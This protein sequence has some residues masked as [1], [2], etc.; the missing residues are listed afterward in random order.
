MPMLTERAASQS[1]F[2]DLCEVLGQPKPT[3]IDLT[4]RGDDLTLCVL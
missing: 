1:H 4:L 3:D 2:I